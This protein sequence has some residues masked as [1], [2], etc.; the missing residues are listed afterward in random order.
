MVWFTGLIYNTLSEK[1]ISF[2]SCWL[3]QI[4][5]CFRQSNAE[6]SLKRL[7]QL[8]SKEAARNHNTVPW[9]LICHK[10]RTPATPPQRRLT[11]NWGS[12]TLLQLCGLPPSHRG[13]CLCQAVQACRV[14][15][16]A[17]SLEI[18]FF[19][20]AEVS[21]CCLQTEGGDKPY[22]DKAVHYMGL[23]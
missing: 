7:W 15:C 12:Y 21:F 3:Q 4:E 23:Y 19:L 20:K 13:W 5:S 18:T 9:I 6:K 14:L 2:F 22:L 16:K 11:G 17:L 10:K 1:K 8:G